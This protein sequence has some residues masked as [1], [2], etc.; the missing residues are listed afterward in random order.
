MGSTPFMKT[1][2]HILYGGT[3][4]QLRPYLYKVRDPWTKTYWTPP[5]RDRNF[6]RNL[7]PDQDRFEPGPKHLQEIQYRLG[8]APSTF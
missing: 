6:L 7:G 4:Q 5:D 1:G 3:Y 2:G 8:P